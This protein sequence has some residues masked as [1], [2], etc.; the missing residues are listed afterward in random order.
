MKYIDNV[1]EIAIAYVKRR[2]VEDKFNRK[3]ERSLS[4]S[5]E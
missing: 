3:V 5:Q 4:F 2:M 1:L